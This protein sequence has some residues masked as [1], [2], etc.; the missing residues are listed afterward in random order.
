MTPVRMRKEKRTHNKTVTLVIWIRDNGIK[1]GSKRG[2]E[3]ER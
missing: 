2:C 1:R 3:K